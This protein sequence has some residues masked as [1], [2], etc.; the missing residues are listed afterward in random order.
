[1]PRPV[2]C[3]G[4]FRASLFSSLSASDC[5]CSAKASHWI[6]ASESL[7]ARAPATHSAVMRRYSAIWSDATVSP[8]VPKQGNFATGEMVPLFQKNPGLRPGSGVAKLLYG[9]SPGRG[10]CPLSLLCNGRPDGLNGSQSP[11]RLR[12]DPTMRRGEH[13]RFYPCGSPCSDRCRRSN[14]QPVRFGNR[15]ALPLDDL[16]S[17]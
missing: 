6:L 2:P 9:A 10:R 1:M 5:Q 11:L 3:L 7:I 4:T 14:G 12:F 13:S 16:P 15:T 17:N 8:S